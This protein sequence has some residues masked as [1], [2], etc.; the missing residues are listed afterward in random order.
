MSNNP[1][2]IELSID[3][4]NALHVSLGLKQLRLATTLRNSSTITEEDQGSGGANND[5][6]TGGGGGIATTSTTNNTSNATTTTTT[7]TAAIAA[8]TALR[9]TGMFSSRSDQSP[10]PKPPSSTQPKF[11]SNHNLNRLLPSGST[12]ILTLGDASILGGGEGSDDDNNCPSGA[13]RRGD[14]SATT[15]NMEDAGEDTIH[16]ATDT[17]AIDD[18]NRLAEFDRLDLDDA[19]LFA[20]EEDEK[21][22]SS[23]DNDYDDEKPSGAR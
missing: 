20:M 17:A 18:N 5:G 2:I 16:Q 7:T 19:D 14:A 9:A 1:K 22:D 3:E 12:T 15:G 13:A 23:E 11:R 6:A 21:D 10:T 4:S 8:A